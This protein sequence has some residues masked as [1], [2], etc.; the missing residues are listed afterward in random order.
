MCPRAEMH[1]VFHTFVL[2][3]C[4]EKNSLY[5]KREV[6]RLKVNLKETSHVYIYETLS[7]WNELANSDHAE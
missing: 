7:Y 6:Y 1:N 5:R 3:E 2:R 4:I